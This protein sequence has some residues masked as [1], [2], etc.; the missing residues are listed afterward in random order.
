MI[1]SYLFIAF[2]TISILGALGAA[3]FNGRHLL[4]RSL[5]FGGAA[6][7][8]LLGMACALDVILGGSFTL[9]LFATRFGTFSFYVDGLSAFFVFMISLLSLVVSVYS[10]GYVKQYEGEYSI[11]LMGFLYNMFILSMALVVTARNAVLFL[12]LWEAMSLTSYALVVYENRNKDAVRSGFIYILMTHAGTAF[13]M[14]S[15]LLLA[16]FTGSFD[17]GAFTGAGAAM[18]YALKSAVF[19]MLLVGFGTKAGI[20]PMH[21]WLPYAHPAAPSNIS[22]LMSGVMVK[23]A[24]YMLIRCYFDFL[25]VTDTWWGL[26][27]LLVASVTAILGV[28]YALMETDIKRLLA[29]STVENVGIIL[30]ALGVAM[31]FE[32]YGLKDF[33]A[34]ALIAALFHALNHALFKGLLFMGAGAVLR[35]TGTRNIEFLGGLVKRMPLTGAFFFVG[36]LAISAIP[37]LNGFVSE[38]LIFQSLLLSSSFPE[39]AV[40]ILI[41]V[42]VGMLAL[43]GALAAACF[44][45]AFGITF[46]ATPRTERAENAVEAPRSMLAGMGM[47]A[48]LCVLG[49]VLSIFIVP[50]IDKVTTP[51]IGA[52]V[53]SKLVYGLVLSPTIRSFSSVSPLALAALLLVILP[54]TYIAS[55]LYG[56]R[57]K[58]R[59]SDTWDCGTPLNAKTEYTGTAF[60]KPIAMIFSS[61]YRPRKIQNTTLTSSPYIKKDITYSDE[62]EPVYEKYLY[63]PVTR[64]AMNIAKRAGAIQTG[65]IQ[66]YLAYIFV[67]LVLLL[68]IFR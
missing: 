17:F 58:T 30:I 34:L 21:I 55:S 16:S 22:A 36:A 2:I 31:V 43:T 10:F 40:K 25:G 29:Y 19:L 52:S 20:I 1:G 28:L 42:T 47:A 56:G 53:A 62:I 14:L 44:V 32:S 33:A 51:V 9:S 26:L 6:I 8:S 24:I 15:F 39:M 7:A 11:G 3:A 63:D 12:I 27:I 68:I 45:R 61:I 66:L 48:A 4:S 64:V 57:Q 13:I 46:L 54:L 41:P 5:A 65:S 37:P 67:T 50:L 18:P 35:A 38:W 49:G 23:T 60:S 59:V